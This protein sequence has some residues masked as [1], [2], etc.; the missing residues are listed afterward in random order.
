[1]GE[2]RCTTAGAAHPAVPAVG[3]PASRRHS[4]REVD[5]AAIPLVDD[6][7]SHEVRVVL[8]SASQRAAPAAAGA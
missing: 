6:G 2:E 4:R 5:P 7:G 8:G 1:M 3:A